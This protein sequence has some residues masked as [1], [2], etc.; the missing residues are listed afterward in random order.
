[1]ESINDLRGEYP[2]LLL[3]DIMSELDSA[4]R[5]YLSDKI[6]DKQVILTC[7][8]ADAAGKSGSAR[9]FEVRSG[10]IIV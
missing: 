10:K 2:V 4:R 3:D 6:K 9:L 8:D 7:T 1:M 5:Q